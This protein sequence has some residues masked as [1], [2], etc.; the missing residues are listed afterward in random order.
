MDPQDI[1]M[2]TVL[3]ILGEK[4]DPEIL[5]KANTKELKK[6]LWQSLNRE[7]FYVL[8][9]EKKLGLSPGFGTVFVKSIKEKDKKVFDKKS[10]KMVTKKVRGSKVIYRPGDSIKSLL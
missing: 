7:L 10:D 5:K 6:K 9:K 1:V 2:Q 4:I 3:E 8:L